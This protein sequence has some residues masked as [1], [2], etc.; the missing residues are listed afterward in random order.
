M[1]EDSSFI[2]SKRRSVKTPK[3]F[4]TSGKPV[5]GTF[6]K[7]FENLNILSVKR[8]TFLPTFMNK[9]KLT[10][11]EAF[12]LSVKGGLLVCGLASMGAFKRVVSIFFDEKEKKVY[13]W[14]SNHLP[15]K[16][17]ICASLLNGGTSELKT[18]KTL[19][20]IINNMEKNEA[21]ISGHDK[22]KEFGEIKYSLILNSI[23]LPSVVSIPFGPRRPLYTEKIFF[24]ASG[25]L[26]V[27]NKTYEC[28][29]DSYAIIDDHKGYYPYTMHY[30]WLTYL[31]KDKDGKDFGLNLTENQST[32][33]E[34]Y[35]ENLIWMKDTS[36]LLPPIHFDKKG[37][38]KH[39]KDKDSTPISWHITDKHNMV[40]LK[41]QI[42]GVDKTYVPGLL[43]YVHYYVVFGTIK[44]GYVMLEDGTK[45]D[46]SGLP[47]IGEDK[48]VRY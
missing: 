48:S 20:R 4:A 15:C 2:S 25:R 12:E 5:F 34:D 46:L 32:N 38:I 27:N 43:A 22:N 18:N 30:D 24:K 14:G 16:G 29:D 17:Q 8:P 23:S 45:K 47:F 35:N 9:M 6:D 10:D 7:E 44:E 19:F 33:P 13:S 39:F 28:D 37:D 31:G 40:D 41:C 11:W 26:I 1:E 42:E 3:D 21:S 36:S